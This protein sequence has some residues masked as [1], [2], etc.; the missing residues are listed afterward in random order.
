M[1]NSHKTAIKRNSISAPAR[2]LRQQKLLTGRVLDYGCGH[3]KDCEE[4][5]IEGYDPYWRPQMPEGKFDTILCTFVV[6]VMSVSEQEQVLNN[7]KALL[8]T[9]GKVY[10]TVRRDLIAEGLT[11][12]HTYQRNVT[13]DLPVIYCKKNKFEIYQLG[14]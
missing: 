10:I 5:N 12:K 3:G 9:N 6:N 14:A 8:S 11:S 7:I 1:N 2:F 4:L 13:L